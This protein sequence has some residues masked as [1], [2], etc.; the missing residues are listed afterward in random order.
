MNII[1]LQSGIEYSHHGKQIWHRKVQFPAASVLLTLA[2]V[3]GAK[4]LVDAAKATVQ[5][6][7]SF[8]FV[9]V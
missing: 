4:A 1:E 7:A 9:L 2:V 3:D 5:A 6:A 8:I